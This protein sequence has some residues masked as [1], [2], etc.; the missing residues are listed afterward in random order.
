MQFGRQVGTATRFS[1]RSF[2]RCF[3]RRGFNCAGGHAPD[4][5]PLQ[6]RL[7]FRG[8][9]FTLIEL[10]VVVVIVGILAAIAY[11][12]YA[13]VVRRANRSSAEQLMMRVA[14]VQQRY[15]LDARSYSATIGSAGLNIV[16]EGWT[17]TTDCSAALYT[18]HVDLVA[19]PPASFKIKATPS[20]AQGVDG[21]LYFNA[22]STYAY[23]PGSKVRT[24]GDGKW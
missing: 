19:G 13:N 24:A 10:M 8:R 3:T 14:S 1:I 22:D 17:C 9:G 21:N 4:D 11:A 2:R 5:S 6:Q 15:F 7:R 20:G 23:S 12:G 16:Q 18:V